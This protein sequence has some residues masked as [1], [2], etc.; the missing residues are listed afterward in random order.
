MREVVPR[1]PGAG[2][3]RQR[4]AVRRSPSGLATPR[5]SR[6]KPHSNHPLFVSRLPRL[7]WNAWSEPSLKK[8]RSSRAE[9]GPGTIIEYSGTRS[10]QMLCP[11]LTNNQD[12]AGIARV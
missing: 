5:R 1:G 11:C 12:D 2:F 7:I 6:S 4:R 3:W 9:A 10:T 8:L